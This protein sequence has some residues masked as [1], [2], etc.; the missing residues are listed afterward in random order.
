M[1]GGRRIGRYH[2]GWPQSAH[3]RKNARQALYK[4]LGLSWFGGAPRKQKTVKTMVERAKETLGRAVAELEAAIP[5]D[6]R[7]LPVE[8]LTGAQALGRAS[9]A[10]LH[11]LI[12]IIE[13]P[14]DPDDLK[15]QRLIGDMALG[16]NKL[17]QRHA[18]G[19]RNHD[20]VAKLLAIL[21]AEKAPAE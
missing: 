4:A 21:E 8:E 18:Q 5:V 12:R 17:L 14:I 1:H 2:G 15:Q 19:E 10:G 6:T 11:Q 16:A 9:L 7:T 20:L 13:Q 3:N